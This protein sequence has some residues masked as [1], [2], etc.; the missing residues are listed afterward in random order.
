VAARDRFEVPLQETQA[1][2]P[3]LLCKA[4]LRKMGVDERERRESEAVR[5]LLIER[6]Y[7]GPLSA[8]R[9]EQT[10]SH[11]APANQARA[12][13]GAHQKGAV[14][15]TATPVG[16]KSGARGDP[17]SVHSRLPLA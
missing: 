13:H 2:S 3:A 4:H 15:V 7:T 14:G 8:V 10:E 9:Q 16:R 1:Y 5:A 17:R 11:G 6:T 12:F